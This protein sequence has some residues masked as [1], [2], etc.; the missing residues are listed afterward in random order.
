MNDDD[1]VQAFMDGSL[2]PGRFHHRDHLRL[3]WLLIRRLDVELAG[4]TTASGIQR[5]AALHGHAEKYHETLTQFWVLIVGHIVHVRP[6]IT[7]FETFIATFPQLLDK[8]L[9][10]RHWQ[11]ETMGAATA[12]AR[13]VEPDLLAL[14]S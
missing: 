1:F 12:R 9:P 4:I 3:A 14:P 10:Y 7:E 13:W 11:R 6:D 5:F 2:P 8:R